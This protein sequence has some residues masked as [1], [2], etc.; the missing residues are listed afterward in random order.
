VRAGHAREAC[1]FVD[2]RSDDAARIRFVHDLVRRSP[3]EA[4][5]FLGRLES[6]ASRL[7]DSL[8][9]TPEALRAYVR[10]LGE[11]LAS[12]AAGLS[13]IDLAC[14]LHDQHPLDPDDL[15][16]LPRSSGSVVDA[17]TRACLGDATARATMLAALAS[18]NDADVELARVYVRHRPVA[19]AKDYRRV[20]VAVARMTD[21]D[22]QA[23]AL[24]TLA[25]Q[26]VSDDASTA[27]LVRVYADARSAD[28]RRAIARILV[29]VD[30]GELDREALTRT[31]RER[32]VASAQGTD[33]IDILIRRLEAH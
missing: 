19:D 11:G 21:P 20:A 24:E 22:A 31:L 28:V 13:D 6:F 30:H 32:R 8:R 16:R 25:R 27:G 33:V 10:L 5:L 9:R 29:L 2:Q 18:A 26:P 3:A 14:R 12:G 15:P 4:R 23:R 1:R 17:A 7:A